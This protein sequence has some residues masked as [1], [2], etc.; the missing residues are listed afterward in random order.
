MC[1]IIIPCCIRIS[2]K[3]MLLIYS[4]WQTLQYVDHNKRKINKQSR[5]ILEKLI[6]SCL[7]SSIARTCRPDHMA[8]II[9]SLNPVSAKRLDSGVG[10]TCTQWTVSSQLKSCFSTQ[11]NNYTMKESIIQNRDKWK[12]NLNFKIHQIIRITKNTKMIILKI[13]ITIFKFA[14]I[15]LAK[16]NKIL[17]DF[18]KR[19]MTQQV[20]KNCWIILSKS[21]NLKNKL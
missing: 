21:K 4:R 15:P 5:K 8:S 9:Y 16:Q 1:Q 20:W 10:P 18:N 2:H 3:P 13:S 11:L 12:I 7:V 19:F 6:G 17:Q 14:M